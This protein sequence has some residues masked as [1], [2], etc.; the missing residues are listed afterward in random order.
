VG[1]CTACRATLCEECATRV[2]GILH[3]R[4]CL[5]RVAA[6]PRTRGG[7]SLPA[8]APALGLGFVVWLLLGYGFYGLVVLLAFALERLAS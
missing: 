2:D 3:C 7:R 1:A 4:A 8:L 5:A 6:R